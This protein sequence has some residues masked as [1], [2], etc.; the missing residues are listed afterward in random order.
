MRRGDAGG[1]RRE[2]VIADQVRRGRLP[3]PQR[4]EDAARADIA[5][6]GAAGVE[7]AR[8]QL[9][10]EVLGFGPL[11]ALVLDESVTDVLVN[12]DA[13]V[14]VDRGDGLLLQPLRLDRPHEQAG[15][16]QGRGGEGGDGGGDA[17]AD[18]EPGAGRPVGGGAQS[19]SPS[20]SSRSSSLL[21]GPLSSSRS[22][23]SSLSSSWSSRSPTTSS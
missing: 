18:R 20:R 16:R 3:D 22:S 13:S 23:R 1:T 5:T 7:Q 15:H 2:E 19:S 6:L 17:G 9:A 14:W 4:V 11:Q 12:G 21:P 8:T 10:A